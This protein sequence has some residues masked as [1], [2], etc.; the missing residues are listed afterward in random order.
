MVLLGLIL[1][2]WGE[3]NLAETAASQSR[4]GFTGSIVDSVLLVL[5]TMI[6]WERLGYAAGEM[7]NPNYSLPVPADRI[8]CGVYNLL[9]DQCRLPQRIRIGSYSGDQP[10]GGR[11]G[12]RTSWPHWCRDLRDPGD[13]FCHWKCQW[14][15]YR[16]ATRLLC[17]GSGW[18]L[19]HWLNYVHPKYRT[20]SRAVLLQCAWG[21]V[22]LLVRGS[23]ESIVTGM[24]FVILIFYAVSTA[25]LFV[26]RHRQVGEDAPIFK[27]PGYPILPAL[28]LLLLLGLILVRGILDWQQSLIDLTFVV[29]GL[30]M[31]VYF[32]R[33]RPKEYRGFELRIP[34][35][36]CQTFVHVQNLGIF[37]HLSGGAKRSRTADLLSAIQ[38]LYHLSYSPGKKNRERFP[39]P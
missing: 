27:V 22:I 29:S 12:D 15:H 16:C 19:F 18:P 39:L 6:G 36:A 2:P 35:K 24:V 33:K 7:K 4:L 38:A 28:Y 30:P 26:L 23:F 32:F 17:D 37:H 31:A 25:A 11:S 8:Y 34:R 10:C 1:L 21:A 14:N 5:F 9:F 20:P 3:N 13:D